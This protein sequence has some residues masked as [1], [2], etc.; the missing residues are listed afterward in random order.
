MKIINCHEKNYNTGKATIVAE[1]SV[2]L[3]TGLELRKMTLWEKEG[4][5]WIGFPSEK[6]QAKD[7][8]TKYAP[9][10]RFEDRA[11]DDAFK[12][13]I[14]ALLSAGAEPEPTQNDDIPF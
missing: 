11:A 7:G 9:Y 12:E 14:L 3:P 2:L 4:R 10:Y 6:Y 5:K 1:F 13:K 8:T